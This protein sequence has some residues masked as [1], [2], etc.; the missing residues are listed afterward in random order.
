LI[1]KELMPERGCL[2][3]AFFVPEI[4]VGNVLGNLPDSG[5]APADC[6]FLRHRKPEPILIHL[7]YVSVI[8]DLLEPVLSDRA[9]MP[10]SKIPL[11]LSGVKTMS[12]EQK[13]NKEAKKKPAMTAKEKKAAKKSKKKSKGQF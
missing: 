11:S 3:V 8:Q 9:V 12:K 2:R 10:C 5:L 6:M 13:S 7:Y 1:A 4:D